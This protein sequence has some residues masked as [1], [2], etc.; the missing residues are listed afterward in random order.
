MTE[1]L[2]DTVVT[3]KDVDKIVCHIFL[4]TLMKRS[5]IPMPEAQEILDS[6]GEAAV[7]RG[8]VVGLYLSLLGCDVSQCIESR[9]SQ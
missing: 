4:Q 3:E 2:H 5:C 7:G 9:R 1:Q 8:M 6:L